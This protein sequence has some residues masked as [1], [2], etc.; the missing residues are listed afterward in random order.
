MHSYDNLTQVHKILSN[1]TAISKYIISNINQIK[2]QDRKII[3][4][5]KILNFNK[6]YKIKIK[7]KIK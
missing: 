1:R 5:K 6:I 4:R 3:N 7:V 2:I